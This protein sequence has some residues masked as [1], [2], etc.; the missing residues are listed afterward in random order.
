M[1]VIEALI[2][3][4]V[5]VLLGYVLAW[6]QWLPTDAGTALAAITFKVFIPVLL[7]TALARA[8]LRQGLSPLLLLAYFGP[9]LLLFA[10]VN[11]IAHR[12]LKRPTTLGLAASYSNNVLVGIPLITVLL[13]SAALVHLFTILVFHSLVLFTAQSLYRDTFSGS[14]RSAGWAALLKSLANPLIIAL[15]LGA[16]FNLLGV[17]LPDA[18][19]RAGDWLAAAALPSALMVLGMSLSRYRLQPSASILSV[20]LVKLLLFPV[21]VFVAATAVGLSNEARTVLTIMAACP[22][23]VN[24]LAFAL[25][26]EDTRIIG[27]VVF[28][29]TLVATISL[30]LWL[31]WLGV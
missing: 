12:R 3:I 7:F 30:T 16:A 28:L 29:S 9:A 17:W 1:L 21:L 14:G 22:T 18:L 13:G 27:S 6:R 19:W 25:G 5:L 4:F 10:G 8:D 20:T 24:V 31:M 11:F 15:L 2:P 23:G 26:H